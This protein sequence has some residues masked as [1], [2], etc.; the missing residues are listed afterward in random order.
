MKGAVAAEGYSKSE[1]S[2]YGKFLK[3]SVNGQRIAWDGL[4]K[5]GSSIPDQR[6]IKTLQRMGLL[7]RLLCR[8]N[9]MSL[10]LLW[11][12]LEPT[13]FA[14]QSGP[15][16][17]W[18]I[19]CLEMEVDHVGM[20]RTLASGEIYY[21]GGESK[22]SHTGT[23][24]FFEATAL[25]ALAFREAREQL[26]RR[27]VLIDTILHLGFGKRGTYSGRIFVPQVGNDQKENIQRRRLC[28]VR[29]DIPEPK[30][31]GGKEMILLSRGKVID[32]GNPDP[33]SLLK[34]ENPDLDESPQMYE[35]YGDYVLR[36]EAVTSTDADSQ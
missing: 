2:N 29:T 25:I 36:L 12:L 24:T 21:E 4:A 14:K 16:N 23:Q 3:D 1:F 6:K 27:F 11:S 19:P 31:F 32:M 26:E 15:F 18:S 7:E 5:S 34:P 22:G 33:F 13:R 30:L 17:K 8:D 10:V 35:E 28:F 20:F 9:R